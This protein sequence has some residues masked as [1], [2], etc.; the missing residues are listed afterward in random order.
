LKIFRRLGRCPATVQTGPVTIESTSASSA[1]VSFQPA[2]AALFLACSGDVAPAI[3]DATSGRLSSHEKASSSIVC[4]RDPENSMPA[5]VAPPKAPASTPTREITICT[6][7]RKRVISANFV[8]MGC[9][10]AHLASL[11]VIAANSACDIPELVS[12]SSNGPLLV[13]FICSPCHLSRLGNMTTG[14][15]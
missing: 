6:V 13:P 14:H 15:R 12:T 3:T 5:S 9:L 7:E 2:A 4:P 10:Q 8:L 11:I 1:S